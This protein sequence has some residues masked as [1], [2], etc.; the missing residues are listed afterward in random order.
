MAHIIH[1]S[2]GSLSG[3]AGNLVFKK[4][5]YGNYVSSA[6]RPTQI[7]ATKGQLRQRDKM[8]CVM[9]FLNA[10]RFILNQTYFPINQKKATYHLIKSYYLK[11]AISENNEQFYINFSKALMSYGMIRPP[12]HLNIIEVDSFTRS[13]TWTSETDQALAQT[14]DE[15][16]VVLYQPQLHQFYFEPNLAFRKDEQAHFKIPEVWQG[17]SPPLTWF[18]YLG[19]EEETASMSVFVE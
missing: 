14:N 5:K 15:L 4:G 16:F 7:P 11:H 9:H 6:P 10:A 2:I 17:T 13:V 18:G 12:A 19:T 8:K 1:N 3:K